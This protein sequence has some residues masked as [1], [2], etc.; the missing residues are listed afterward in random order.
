M[1]TGRVSPRL[2][3]LLS[4]EI[5]DADGQPHPVEVVLDT[6][7][8]GYLAL[9]PL[10]I[11]QLALTPEGDQQEIELADG[12]IVGLSLYT[13]TILWNGRPRR[14]DVLEADSAP[15]LGMNLLRGSRITLEVR[16][17]GPVTV[18]PLP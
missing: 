8:E 15:L 11:R 4:V 1:L 13:G 16:P 9:P 7:F 2:Q 3:A 12:E 6:G 5:L 10:I 14:V 17:R 18:T